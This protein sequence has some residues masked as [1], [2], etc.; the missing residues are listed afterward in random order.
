MAKDAL[1][2]IPP[3]VLVADLHQLIAESRHQAAVAV[4]VSLTA[5]YWRVGPRINR[6]LLEGDRAEYGA[7]LIYPTLKSEHLDHI[8]IGLAAYPLTFLA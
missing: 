7:D 6:E 5:F 3:G 2:P 8:H 1:V 4:N